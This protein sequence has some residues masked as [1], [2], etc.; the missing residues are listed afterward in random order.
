MFQ[1]IKKW[2]DTFVVN[3]SQ[4][5]IPVPVLRDPKTNQGSVSLTLVFISFNVWLASVIGKVAGILGGM[6]PDQCLNMFLAA[7]ALYW[8]RK[9]QGN[10]QELSLP[11]SQ[12]KDESSTDPVSQGMM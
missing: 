12:K 10:G 5:G 1:N 11:E 4:R 3:V 9:F 8:G 2:W 7:S 6:N